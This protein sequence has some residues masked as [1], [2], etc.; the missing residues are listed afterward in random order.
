MILSATRER[1]LRRARLRRPVATFAVHPLDRKAAGGPRRVAALQGRPC[2]RGEARKRCST[3]G[4]GCS[5][6]RRWRHWRLNDC[7]QGSAGARRGS[8]ARKRRVQLVEG[9]L[10]ITDCRCLPRSRWR[11][12]DPAMAA[13][14]AT[15]AMKVCLRLRGRQIPRRCRCDR[16]PAHTDQNMAGISLSTNPVIDVRKTDNKP[17]NSRTAA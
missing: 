13:G 7:R 12:D 6:K 5:R 8:G 15:S 17:L 4:V 16:A 11:N 2:E 10:H 3:E 14:A 1:V 9:H